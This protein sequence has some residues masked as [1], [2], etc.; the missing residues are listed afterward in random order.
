MNTAQQSR[1]Q[2]IEHLTACMGGF[3]GVREGCLRHTT[4]ERSN[5]LERVCRDGQANAFVARW[6][7]PSIGRVLA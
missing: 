3:C 4:E 5:P 7:A 6:V 2:R 1:A